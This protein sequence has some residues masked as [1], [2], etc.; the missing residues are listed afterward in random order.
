MIISNW[1]KLIDSNYLINLTEK[2]VVPVTVIL[3]LVLAH[4]L[5]YLTW[6]ILPTPAIQPAPPRKIV[7]QTNVFH[8]PDVD[9]ITSTHLFG[10]VEVARPMPIA[11]PETKLN[12]I[13]R[14]I[15]AAVPPDGGAII[16]EPSGKEKF[17]KLGELIVFND[18]TTGPILTDV[19]AKHV[20]IT[21]N[22]RSETLKL[23]ELKLNEQKLAGVNLTANPAPL[24]PNNEPPNNNDTS[25]QSLSYYRDQL[26]NNPGSVINLMQAQPVY[27][28]NQIQGFRIRPTRKS[29]N[30]FKHYGLQPNDIITSINGVPLD[31]PMKAFE[32]LRDLRNSPNLNVELLRQGHP[33]KINLPFDR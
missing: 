8:G 11:T 3:I 24:N 32:V 4:T 7:T 27:Q 20:I 12:L 26:F 18:E 25:V 14:G 9:T 28:G 30:L 23:P 33:E 1:Y 10:Q 15:M 17:F 13:L 2:L 19:Y 5:A 6:N 21:H 31:N 29:G 22:G 16:A